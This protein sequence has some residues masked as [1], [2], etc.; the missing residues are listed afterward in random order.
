MTED[1]WSFALDLYAQPGVEAACLDLQEAGADVCLLLAG[2]WF[3]AC[4]R[5]CSGQR[6]DTLAKASANWQ[7]E[8]VKP[9]RTLRQQWKTA[10]RN[11]A[12]LE[13]LRE[14]L[15]TLELRAERLQL[16]RLAEAGR[17]WTEAGRDELDAWLQGCAGE[18]GKARRSALQQ[19]RTAAASRAAS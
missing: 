14:T 17:D 7:R 8:V 1:I 10:A 12:H 9:L 4:G 16:E 18:A 2:A 13:K 5:A 11:D 3:A 6:L 15:K 19:L